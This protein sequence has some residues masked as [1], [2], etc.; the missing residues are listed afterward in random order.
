MAE[1]Q[2]T[3][4]P[5]LAGMTPAA[6]AERPRTLKLAVIGMWIGAGLAALGVLVAYLWTTSALASRRAELEATYG[7]GYGVS[8]ATSHGEVTL[9]VGFAAVIAVVEIILWAT[10]AATNQKGYPWARIVATALGGTSLLLAAGGV[11]LSAFQN[12]MFAI[13]VAYTVVDQAVSIT[14][15]I[16]LWHPKSSSYFRTGNVR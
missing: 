10:M 15:L 12:N 11:A 14:V 6:R 16:L 1:P 5:L 8:E 4:Q 2:N 7:E 3:Q 9:Y 13:P